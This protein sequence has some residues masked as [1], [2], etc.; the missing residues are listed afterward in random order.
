LPR[1]LQPRSLAEAL[2][3]LADPG[4]GLTVLAGAT[5]AYPAAAAASAWMRPSADAF[6]DI[7]ALSELGGI[8]RT[9]D[10]WRLGALATWSA[11][12]AADLPPAFDGLRTAARQVGGR[13]IQ[14]R[15]TLGGNLCNASPAADGG[16]PLLALCAEVEL[17]SVRGIRRMPL[18]DFLL[19]NRRTALAPDELLTGI[20]LPEPSAAGRA[21]FLKLGA[22]A[23]L[24]IS[25]VSVAANARIRPDGTLADVRI[26]FGAASAA[27]VRDRA[28]EAAV[29]GLTPGEAAR[30]LRGLFPAAIS[31]IDDVRASARYRCEA[32]RELAARALAALAVGAGEEIAA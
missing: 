28:L 4:H 15:G 9:P 29:T 2:S 31:P 8:G 26:A 20:I 25:I 16:P 18:G 10:G 3:A 30:A 17:A 14:N 1:Y 27:P 11:V 23:Y 19:G 13:Q 22:R 7:S 32:A 5:D 21:V 12:I 6:L 24:V